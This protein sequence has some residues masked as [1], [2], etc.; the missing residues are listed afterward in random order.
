[1]AVIE[2]ASGY[3]ADAGPVAFQSLAGPNIGPQHIT[4]KPIPYGVGGHYKLAIRVPLIAAQAAN[5]RLLSLRNSSATLLIVPTRL[6]IRVLQTA[7]FT[8][9]IEDSI[10][11]FKVTAFTVDDTTN[12][13]TPTIGKRRTS[14]ASS[15]ASIRAVASAGAAAGMTGGT[16]TKD[17]S[18]FSQ[19]PN[20]FQAAVPTASV[21][22]PTW[23]GCA[24]RCERYASS[25]VH[26]E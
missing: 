5:S 9:A 17:G 11:C 23:Q 12:T 3:I 24:G 22:T 2:G 4:Q 8:A 14:M 10:D 21:I 13:Q 25:C 16:L 19:L 7:A 26:A 20:F 6:N 1:M 18:P 15:I